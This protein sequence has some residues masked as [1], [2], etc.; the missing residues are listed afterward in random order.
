M[1]IKGRADNRKCRVR[2]YGFSWLLILSLCVVSLAMTGKGFTQAPAKPI[3]EGSGTSVLESIQ[4][5]AKEV[6]QMRAALQSPDQSVRVAAFWA[7]VNSGNPALSEM[8]ITTAFANADQATKVLAVRAA[9]AS[10][11]VLEVELTLPQD[12][13]EPARRDLGQAIGHGMATISEIK[14]DAKTGKFQGRS[15][16]L[17][18]SGQVSG[19]TI[20][21]KTNGC[22]GTLV[23]KE[24][25]WV[26]QGKVRC[27]SS[28]FAGTFRL[29]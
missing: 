12:A 8:A 19:I 18:S 10:V 2:R 11:Q 5:E 14:Y 21:F 23:N 15:M 24:G 9:F 13:S 4:R 6:E 25:T 20:S 28:V 26:F 22:S 1:I 27:E 7:M 3:G 29:R 17:D 16:S